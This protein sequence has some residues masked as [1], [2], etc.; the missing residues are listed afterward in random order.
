[1]SD[2]L[3]EGDYLEYLES[4]GRL[5]AG[6]RVST[7][8]IGFVPRERPV[9]KPL[10][11][12]LTLLLLDK[13]TED[14]AGLFTRN[15]FPGAPVLIGRERLKSA[16]R[17]RGVLINNKVSNVCAPSGVQDAEDIL[18]ALGQRFGVPGGEFFPASTG[19]VGWGLPVSDMKAGLPSL[20]ANLH[21][22]SCADAARAIMTTDAYAKAHSVPV[23][24][25]GGI[26]TGF[27]KGAGMIEPNLATMLVF[28]MTDASVS[29]SLMQECLARVC[30]RTFNC[31]SVDSDQST[32][33]TVLFFS[34]GV[35]PAPSGVELEAALEEVCGNLARNIVRGGEGTAHVIRVRVHGAAD[36]RL[37]RD[38]GK[39]V[40]NSPLVKSAVYGNDPNV[41]RIVS[42][43]GDFAGNAGIDFDPSALVVRLG[44]ELIFRRGVFELNADKEKSLS[45]Y[46]K[47]AYMDPAHKTYPLHERCVEIDIEM[48]GGEAQAIVYGSD[49]SHEYI[50]EN[51]DYRS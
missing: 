44:P 47:Q 32:S 20:V 39:A 24:G 15:R 6:F 38:F 43:L 21:G 12:R 13:P 14:F 17:V 11:M 36:F 50:T 19:I 8:E 5:P 48:G 30:E 27:A 25:G 2:F 41:G 33:D 16:G 49:L 7:A 26:L 29:R 9:E 4:A 10:P 35:K 34:S 1:M 18:A 3:S 23:G 45:D 37:A 22:G 46:L 51:A 31:V 28:L 40:V 42:S